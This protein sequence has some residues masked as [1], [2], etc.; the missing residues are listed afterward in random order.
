MITVF[1]TAV[2]YAF[3]VSIATMVAATVASTRAA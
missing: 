3:F 2:T 1:F